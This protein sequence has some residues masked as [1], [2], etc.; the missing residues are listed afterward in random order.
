MNGAEKPADADHTARWPELEAVLSDREDSG[1]SEAI[2]GD[3]TV[4]WE[5]IEGFCRKFS[6][7]AICA[8]ISLNDQR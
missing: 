5:G 6:V 1:S 3:P 8:M 4:P 2:G 7:A